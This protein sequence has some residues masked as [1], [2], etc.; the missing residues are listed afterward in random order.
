MSY[1]LD[2][3]LD[4]E[5]RAE[6][7]R[8]DAADREMDARLLHRIPQPAPDEGRTSEACRRATCAAL[9]ID[10]DAPLAVLE[11]PLVRLAALVVG[12]WSAVIAVIWWGAA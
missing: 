2:T 12:I 1:L 5:R 4:A 3:H 7:E 11:S 8:H 10:P 6:C 9:G